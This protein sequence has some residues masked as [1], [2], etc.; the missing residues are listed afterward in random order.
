[1]PV[2]QSPPLPQQ[3]SA[4]QS[5]NDLFGSLSNSG[6]SQQIPSPLPSARGQ[7]PPQPARTPDPFAALNSPTPRQG[8]PMHFQQNIKP[9][10]AASGSVD[11]LGGAIPAPTSNLAQST[12]ATTND[13]DEWTF[14]SAVPDMSKEITVNNTVINV[15]FKVSRESDTV[16]LIQNRISNN[17]PQPISDLTFQV[18]ASKVNFKIIVDIKRWLTDVGRTTATRAS[19]RCHS[20]SQPARWNHAKHTAEWRT[21]RLRQ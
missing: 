20:R 8:S 6:S 2:P 11:L 5:I 9:T 15:V 1:M 13:D 17:N 21:K 18:A 19:I 10:P 4:A 12:T 3:Q 14:S 16:L 7:P